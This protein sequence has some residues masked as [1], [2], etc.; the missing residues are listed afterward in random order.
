VNYAVCTM[1][2]PNTR[3]PI[4]TNGRAVLQGSV[5]VTAS[6]PA[7]VKR[8]TSQPK[9]WLEKRRC[10]YAYRAESKKELFFRQG[11]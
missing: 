7:D 3:P 9:S 8:R 5:A 10:T 4:A 2:A 11:D 6:M 1:T